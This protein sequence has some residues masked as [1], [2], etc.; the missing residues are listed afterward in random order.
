MSDEI[1]RLEEEIDRVKF[2]VFGEGSERGLI[3]DMDELK[4]AAGK[5]AKHHRLLV[6]SEDGPTIPEQLREVTKTVQGARKALYFLITTIVLLVLPVLGSKV[7]AL[8]N[9]VS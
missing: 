9:L 1:Q 4:L 3:R 6:E 7:L 8:M 2:V 5:T